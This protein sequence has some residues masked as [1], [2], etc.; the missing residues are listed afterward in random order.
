MRKY[1]P[2]VVDDVAS[3]PAASADILIAAGDAIEIYTRDDV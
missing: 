3:I 2:F 1:G